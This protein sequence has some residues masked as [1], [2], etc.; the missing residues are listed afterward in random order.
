M[1]RL[2]GYVFIGLAILV[3]VIFLAKGL[4]AS[5]FT[6]FVIAVIS[7]VWFWSADRSAVAGL[8]QALVAAVLIGITWVNIEEVRKESEAQQHAVKEYIEQLQE[9]RR[10]ELLPHV[11][12]VFYYRHDTQKFMAVVQNLGV[13]PAFDIVYSYSVKDSTDKELSGNGQLAALAAGDETVDMTIFGGG[14]VT[15]Q[16]EVKVEVTYKD[17]FGRSHSKQYLHRLNDLANNP[18]PTKHAEQIS[19]SLRQESATDRRIRDQQFLEALRGIQTEISK[20]KER[21]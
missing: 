1:K 21:N 9:G 7:A 15:L 11:Y 19:E 20:V 6:A 13:G 17:V 5:A 14:L 2:L 12:V 16:N 3:G 4:L 8:F 18:P 10:Q